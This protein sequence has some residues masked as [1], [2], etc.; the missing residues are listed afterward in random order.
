MRANLEGLTGLSELRGSTGQ[1]ETPNVTYGDTI[2]T[3]HADAG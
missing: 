1:L 3:W 2:S